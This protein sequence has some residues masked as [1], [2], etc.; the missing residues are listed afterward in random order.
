MFCEV[1]I[2]ASI[3]QQ[4]LYH[5]HCRNRIRNACR[6][7]YLIVPQNI[8]TQAQPLAERVQKQELGQVTAVLARFASASLDSGI[9]MK[10]F[11]LDFLF[12]SRRPV[13][14]ARA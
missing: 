1:D 14:R 6:H 11:L 3:P 5:F 8:A 13:E 12:L 2:V 9:E 4:L 10:Y 7:T